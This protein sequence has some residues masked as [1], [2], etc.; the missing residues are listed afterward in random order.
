MTLEEVKKKKIGPC[1]NSKGNIL[2]NYWRDNSE[3]AVRK[4]NNFTHC[5]L[6]APHLKEVDY[7]MTKTK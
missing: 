4:I 7:E 2:S 3:F 6:Q 5:D 1:E